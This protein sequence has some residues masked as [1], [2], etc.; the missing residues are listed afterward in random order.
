MDV[1]N[2]CL[3]IPLFSV[4]HILKSSITCQL[5]PVGGSFASP[6]SV[7]DKDAPGLMGCTTSVEGA[8][9][10]DSVWD[11]PTLGYGHP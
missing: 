1:S 2:S 8:E 5:L 6:T 4:V 11:A 10:M 3:N 7:A 9:L